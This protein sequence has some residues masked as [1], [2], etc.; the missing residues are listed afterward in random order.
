[1][2]VCRLTVRA[3]T[4]EAG[5]SK[6]TCHQILTENF[7]MHCVVPKFVPHLLSED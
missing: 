4:E 2:F 3:V 6:T 5:I 1:M 7:G